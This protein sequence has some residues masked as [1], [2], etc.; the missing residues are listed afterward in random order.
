MYCC[1]YNRVVTSAAP[2]LL[3]YYSERM[4]LRCHRP[5][6]TTNLLSTYFNNKT[7]VIPF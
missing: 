1:E 7:I 5:H 6:L 2:V 4:F 3:R